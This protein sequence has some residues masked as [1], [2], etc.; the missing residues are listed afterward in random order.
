MFDRNWQG[1]RRAHVLRGAYQY[2]RPDQSATV[3]ADL[4]LAAIARDPGELPPVIDVETTGGKRPEQIAAAVQTW[5]DRVRA[6]LGVEPIVYTSPDFWR[7]RVGGAD[8]SS[9]PLW[10]AHYTDGCPRV[11]APWRRWTYWQH[12]KT[13]RVAGIEGPV[14]LDVFAGTIEELRRSADRSARR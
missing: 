13:G 1:A 8:L 5:V 2:F 4:L 12:S 11:P 6:G 10:L 14:D 9:Q 3:Q 7:D